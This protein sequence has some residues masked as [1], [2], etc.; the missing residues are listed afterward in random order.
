ML[1]NGKEKRSR[2]NR[3]R[4]KKANKSG[5]RLSVFKSAKHLYAQ[6]IDDDKGVTICSAST[7]K[8]PKDKNLCNIVNAKLI[9]EQIGKAAVDKGVSKLYLDRGPNMYHGIV[10]T[11]ADS[12]RSL[13]L[14]F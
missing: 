9:G 13:G 5:L 10:K 11:L 14:K 8:M 3:Y 1:S 6:V 4:L 7:V 2:R 12:V